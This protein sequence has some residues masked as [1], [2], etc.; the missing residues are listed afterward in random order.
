MEYDLEIT[1]KAEAKHQ[2]ADTLAG[3][4]TEGTADS[5]I[6]DDIRVMAVTTRA[7]SRQSKIADH[8]SKRTLN[9]TRDRA[10]PTIDQFLSAQSSNAY[11]DKIQLKLEI[12]RSSFNIGTNG[13]LVRLSPIDSAVRKV[14]PHLMLLIILCLDHRSHLSGQSVEYQMYDRLRPECDWPNIFTNVYST[15]RHFQ[16]R[17]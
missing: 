17:L 13:L 8:T 9:E 5:D 11:S 7:Q 12:R 10:L 6:E 1:H 3:Q 15:V 4:N 16:D 14:V 2:A